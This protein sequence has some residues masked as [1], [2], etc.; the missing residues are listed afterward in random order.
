MLT[1]NAAKVY[2][3]DFRSSIMA[4][5]SRNNLLSFSFFFFLFPI[6]QPQLSREG[7]AAKSNH[8]RLG[9]QEVRLGI[10]RLF[11]DSDAIVSKPRLSP[12]LYIQ[13]RRTT[14]NGVQKK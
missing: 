14:Q 11:F 12:A 1:V 5:T 8:R 7:F 9:S 6:F 10:R 3:E 13:R 4:L 2:S